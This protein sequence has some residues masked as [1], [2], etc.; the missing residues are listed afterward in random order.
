[1]D[2]LLMDLGNEVKGESSVPGHERKLDLL[3]FSHGVAMHTGDARDP[4]RTSGRPQHMDMSV[5]RHLDS[6]TPQ[7]NQYCCEGKPFPQVD[8]IVGRSDGGKVAESMRYTLRNVII[9]SIAVGGGGGTEPVETLT[10]NYTKIT[11]KFT[12]MVAGEKK[13]IERTWDLTR[14]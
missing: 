4:D 3:S 12:G 6:A 5:T 10:L 8:I 13:T 9:S 2:V 7:L 14:S 1:M 11:W